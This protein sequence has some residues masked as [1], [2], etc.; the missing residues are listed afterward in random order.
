M[1]RLVLTGHGALHKVIAT[2]EG[3]DFLLQSL[4]EKEQ[5]RH[6]FAYFT[7]IEDRTRPFLNLAER[8]ELP[9]VTGNYL[10][11]FDAVMDLPSEERAKM[12]REMASSQP[13]LSKYKNLLGKV[14]DEALLAAFRRAE[15]LGA[16]MLTEEDGR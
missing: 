14:S 9:D 4:N 11:A 5:F 16:E 12:L 7:R 13:E 2:E 6:L 8:R 1:V 15:V 10:K 3:R